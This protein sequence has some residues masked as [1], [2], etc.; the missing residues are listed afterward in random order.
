MNRLSGATRVAGVIGDPVAHSLSPT[1]HNAAFAALGIDWVSVAFPIV[2]SAGL[3]AVEAM[4]ILGLAGLSVTTPHKDAVAKTAD[5]VSE[6]VAML[7]AANCLVACADGKIRAENT[8]GEGFLVG[9]HHDTAAAVANKTVVV[10]GAGGAARAITLACAQAGASQIGIVNRNAERGEVCA[11]LAGASG[12]VATES[13]I[14]EADIVVNATSVGMT[15]N[16]G[17]PCDPKLLHP[18]QIAVDIVYNP[19]E[20]PWLAALRKAGIS[21]HNGLSMLVNQAAAA[22]THWT[23]HDAPH[24]T[25]RAALLEMLSERN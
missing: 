10:I 21:A 24:Q 7:G 6:E 25:M 1:L 20:T 8:D 2:A 19:L 16:N 22:I 15:P 5:V 3:Q 14:A 23:G 18:G 9:L 4:R 13:A 11:S 17:M 12:V